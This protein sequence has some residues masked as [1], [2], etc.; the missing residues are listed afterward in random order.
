MEIKTKTK[1][2]LKALK[3]HLKAYKEEG[4][5][6][7]IPKR[8]ND[9]WETQEAFKFDNLCFPKG[10]ILPG[11]S[12]DCTFRLH[13]V[14]PIWD[15]ALLCLDDEVVGPLGDWEK[16]FNYL[17]IFVGGEQAEFCIVVKLDDDKCPVGYFEESN[18]LNDDIEDGIHMLS[19][20]LD[21]FLSKL[22][23]IKEVSCEME[24]DKD[25]IKKSYYPDNDDYL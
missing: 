11:W 4:Y 10:T 25:S 14:A 23:Q 15:N 20:S 18:C 24:M 21:D 2:A 1:L 22:T 16:A 5:N 7:V 19:P 9:F 8:L 12:D 17:P 6:P 13:L 3:R